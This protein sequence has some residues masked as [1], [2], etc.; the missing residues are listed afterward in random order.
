MEPLDLVAGDLFDCR[1]DLR[2]GVEVIGIARQRVP[3]GGA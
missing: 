2:Q 1:N 3:F